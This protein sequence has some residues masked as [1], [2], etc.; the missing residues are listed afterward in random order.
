MSLCVIL[1]GVRRTRNR[2]EDGVFSRTESKFC[3]GEKARERARTEQNQGVPL[4]AYDEGIYVGLRYNF[5]CVGYI[6]ESV[7]KS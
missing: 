3:A 2:N 1:S 7:Q 6:F 5:S 4:A